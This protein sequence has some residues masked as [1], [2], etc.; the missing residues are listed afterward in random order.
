[1]AD[2]HYMTQEGLDKLKKDLDEAIVWYY[3]AAYE[4]TPVLALNSGQREPIEGLVRCYEALDM[5]ELA[6][7]FRRELSDVKR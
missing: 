1:M 4:T 3:N 6:Y 7:R 2:I 5:P